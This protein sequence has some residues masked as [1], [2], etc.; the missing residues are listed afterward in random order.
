[1]GELLWIGLKAFFITLVLTPIIRDIFR[2]FNVVDRPGHRK[3]HTHPIPRVGGL[4]IAIAYAL[5]LLPFRPPA[6][7]INSSPIDAWAVIPAAAIVLLVGLLDDLF[8]LK[9]LLKLAGLVIA[10]SVAYSRGLHIGDVFFHYHLAAPIDYLLTVFWL[11]LTSNALNLIDGLD[12]LC[13]GMGLLSSLTLFAAAV[14]HKNVPLAHA[15]FPLAAA[16]AGF[17]CYNFNP[18]TVFLGDSGALLIGFLLGSYGMI[19]CQKSETLLSILVPMLALSIP[20]LDVSL[21]VLRR[22]I[23]R[24][25]IFSADRGHIHHRLIDRGLSTRQAVLVLYSVGALAAAFALLASTEV[26]GHYQG[27]IIIVFGAAAWLGIRKLRYAEFDLPYRLMFSPELQPANTPVG[28]EALAS[29]LE[30]TAGEDAWWGTL[31]HEGPKLGFASLLWRREPAP[32]EQDLAPGAPRSWSLEIPIPGSGSVR[33]E[34]RSLADA[35]HC[36]LPSLTEIIAR[37]CPASR[38]PEP[39]RAQL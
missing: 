13:A 25:P 38:R 11:V 9:P 35:P 31:V 32:R 33:I 8:S 22:M 23:R 19:W 27:I 26:L 36:D 3:V 5:A 24:Q 18:A 39:H 30:A 14:L 4:A 37:T 1:M 28:L 10:A 17:L 20:L 29:A 6:S 16:L 21:S 12:G 15:T 2:S 7:P 34:G